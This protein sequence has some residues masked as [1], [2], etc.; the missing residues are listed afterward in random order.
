MDMDKFTDQR[1]LVTKQYASDANLNARITLHER[2]ST[3]PQG[4]YRWYFEQITLP[5]KARL[6]EVGC[7]PGKLWLRNL[8]HI[9]P[10]WD[11]ILSDLSLG[12]LRSA[13]RNLNA[14]GRF[15]FRVHDVQ[16]LPYENETFDAVFA[17]HMLYHVPNLKRALLEIQRVLKPG[18]MLYAA[19]NGEHHMTEIDDLAQAFAERIGFSLEEGFSRRNLRFSLENGAEHLR[20]FFSQIERR[21]YPDALAVTEA[22]PLTNYLLSMTSAVANLDATF[23]KQITQRLEAFIEQQLQA[24]GGIITIHKATGLFI[25]WR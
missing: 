11:I 10:G 2:F 14:T 1:Y 19:T 4:W 20:P 12:M 21:D 24:Q 6:L 5:P 17:N 23:R 16:L 8:E 25:A 13:E 22:K 15:T 9:P 18:G 3:N 7:G